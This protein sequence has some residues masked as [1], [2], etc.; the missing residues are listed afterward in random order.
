MPSS[1]HGTR[2]SH[3]CSQ[4]FRWRCRLSSNLPSFQH[5]IHQDLGNTCFTFLSSLANFDKHRNAKLICNALSKFGV[6]A[7]PSGRNDI[8]V[9]N[10]KVKEFSA[11]FHFLDQWI[12]LQN[13][14]ETC[15]S[16]RNFIDQ[17]KYGCV[18]TIFERK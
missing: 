10:L 4:I 7:A 1:T 2:R 5:L 9:N 16:S 8:L 18:S 17:C 13:E 6:T 15:V 3:S 11:N 12:R 14:R